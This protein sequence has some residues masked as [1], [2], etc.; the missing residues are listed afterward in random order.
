MRLIIERTEFGVYAYRETERHH[1][2]VE[3]DRTDAG[4]RVPVTVLDDEC[5]L[6]LALKAN[7]YIVVRI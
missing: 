6:E 1:A 3:P 2:R 4:R 7:E 5:N